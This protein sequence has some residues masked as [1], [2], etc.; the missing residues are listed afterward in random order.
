M[1]GGFTSV[2]RDGYQ[3]VED[4]TYNQPQQP[5]PPRATPKAP[6]NTN[7]SAPGAYEAV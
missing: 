3:T 7:T 4:E 1:P 2:A 5:P 6:T